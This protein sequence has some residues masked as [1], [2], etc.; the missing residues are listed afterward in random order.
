MLN[1]LLKKILLR[2]QALVLAFSLVISFSAS[3]SLNSHSSVTQADSSL[4]IITVGY[5]KFRFLS[6]NP[7]N[8][9]LHWKTADGV[10]YRGFSGLR[11]HLLKRGKKIV[12]LMNA[13][14]YTVNYQ[15][16]GLHIENGEILHQINTNRGKGNFHL[17][18]NGVF[19]VNNSGRATILTTNAYQK[20]YKGKEKSLALAVQSG[21]MLIIDGHI[22]P[23]FITDSKSEY[24]RNGV[25]T[26]PKGK[27]F[28]FA[29]D[30]FPNVTSNLY[31]FAKAAQTVGC[32]NALYLDG[33]IS[34]LYIAGEDMYFHFSQ[35][36][37]ILAVTVPEA[38]GAEP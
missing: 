13:G 34:K 15:P 21:P 26:T 18:P 17:Q 36:V 22:N 5:K 12:A 29:T 31:Q 37:G 1:L 14:I 27:V 9:S 25:C 3:A 8:I 30:S 24:A 10:A 32:N 4:R 38:E 2:G 19:L 16:A 28:F 35:Y 11:S 7:K 20:Y 6:V 33:N 23:R